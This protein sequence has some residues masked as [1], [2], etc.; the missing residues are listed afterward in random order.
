MSNVVAQAQA[1]L[2]ARLRELRR[3]ARL[4]GRQ[5][6][7]GC[8]WHPTKVS[9]IENGRRRPSEADLLA[10]CR[11]V[12][13]T[14]VYDDLVASLRNLRSMYLEWRRT[15]AAGHTH[16]QRQIGQEFRDARH[17]RWFEESIIPG[18]LQTE[19]Y[20]R[21]ILTG[22]LS[23]LPGVRDDVDAAV[24]QR[25]A[26]RA[27]LRAGDRRFAFLIHEAALRRTV[28]DTPVMR[29]QLT[30]LIDD[31]ANPRLSLG[32]IPLSAR[33]VCPTHGFTLFDRSSVTIETISAELTVTRPSEI[34]IYEDTFAA[35]NKVAI[36][37]TNANTLIDNILQTI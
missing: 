17:I 8:G 13:N 9:H 1:A 28:G 2:G 35:M 10:W 5:L 21:A 26:N 33:W 34:A 37:G 6:A 4:T 32:V 24:R 20:A 30:R 7:T 31:I 11:A 15:L 18:I 3:D 22:C 14:L 25:T 19:A 36:H 27:V 12:D 16:A 29:E 23:V